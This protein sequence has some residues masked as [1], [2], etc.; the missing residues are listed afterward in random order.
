[1]VELI[2]LQRMSNRYGVNPDYVLAGGGN[3]SYKDGNTL[4]VKGSG[5]SLATIKAE[6]FVRLDRTKLNAMWSKKYSD[7]EATR[8]SEVLADMMLA[9]VEGETRRP[10]V[11]TLLHDI[12]PYSF[13]LH[14]HPSLV[15]G[16]TCGVNGNEI[17]KRLFPESVWVDACR[18]GYIL[19]SICREKLNEY[20]AE[21]GKD[22]NL[23][24]LQ[25]H[26]LFLAGNT[27]EDID[28]LANNVMTTISDYI[29]SATMIRRNKL[30][31]ATGAPYSCFIDY[32][33]VFKIDFSKNSPSPDHIVYC[34]A[35][36][37]EVEPAVS[38]DKLSEAIR[39]FNETNGYN[40]RVII[41]K[42]EGA[43]IC[44]DDEKTLNTVK[45]VFIDHCNVASNAVAFGGFL[46]M[47]D[48][49]RDFIINWEVESYRAKQNK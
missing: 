43:I 11:E 39:R 33:T 49:L 35:V 10:S 17:S 13:V 14:V 3:T 28:N 45:S 48:D 41:V 8:E 27:V 47:K 44:A 20:K 46:P 31:E 42:G 9:R 24:F 21:N 16:M 22:A 40:P 23:L 26:G 29:K 32:P 6:D 1:M 19:A 5:T 4:Y 15:N 18:P 7:V 37:L 2:E 12:F 30:M 25:N 38:A 34:K 36:Y